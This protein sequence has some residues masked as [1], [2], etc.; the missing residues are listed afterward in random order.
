MYTI[1]RPFAP[2]TGTF[3]VR[4]VVIAVPQ[5]RASTSQVIFEEIDDVEGPAHVYLCATPTNEH[6]PV[7]SKIVARPLRIKES[8]SQGRDAKV[9]AKVRQHDLIKL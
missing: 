2:A 4:Q 3:T 9:Q 5:R 8:K 7:T 6:W 1:D